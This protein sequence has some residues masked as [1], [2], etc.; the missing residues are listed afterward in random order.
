MSR[1]LP[2]GIE[3][4]LRLGVPAD[5]REPIS[6]DLEEDYALLAARYGTTRAAVA[7]W[8]R[9]AR[10]TA[11]MQSLLFGVSAAD[12][13]V[14]IGVSAILALVAFAAAAVPSSRATRVDPLTAIRSM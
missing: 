7:T 1:R 2:P 12:P 9:T 11:S 10:V 6:G 4:L 13:V 8:W 3:R 5:Q 14:Y